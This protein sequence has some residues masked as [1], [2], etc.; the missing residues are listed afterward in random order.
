MPV[1]PRLPTTM[2]SACFWVANVD[3]DLSRVDLPSVG[4]RLDA[5]AHGIMCGTFEQ[6]LGDLPQVD[7]LDVPPTPGAARLDQALG[8]VGPD[9]RPLSDHLR[10]GIRGH[11]VEP[12]AI[13]KGQVGRLPDGSSAGLEPSIPTT[14]GRATCSSALMK[15]HDWPLVTAGRIRPARQ[16]GRCR[17]GLTDSSALRCSDGGHGTAG[18]LILLHPH[19]QAIH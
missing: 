4:L 10:V 12:R 13:T 16:F 9:R 6:R 14:I 18:E 7:G 15:R 2:R 17:L 5:F 19:S 3:D 1:R 11:R 8:I